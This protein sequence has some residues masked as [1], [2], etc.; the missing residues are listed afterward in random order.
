M[1]AYDEASLSEADLQAVIDYLLGKAT[2]PPTPKIDV[3]KLLENNGCLGCHS[4]DGSESIAPTFKGIGGR[5]VTVIRNG[6]QQTIKV[7]AAYLQ[8]ALLKPNAELVK[9]FPGIMPAADY[10]AE[11]E[12]NALIQHLLQQ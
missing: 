5:E 3:T 1:P 7:D 2:K 11:E 12:I 4:T 8:R 10:L 9:G 6:Q